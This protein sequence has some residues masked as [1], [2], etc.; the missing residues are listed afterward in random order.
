MAVDQ[1]AQDDMD[2][3][4][5]SKFAFM[6]FLVENYGSNNSTKEEEPE[7]EVTLFFQNTASR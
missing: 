5:G 2:F 3:F 6:V 1:V 4:F 7:Q